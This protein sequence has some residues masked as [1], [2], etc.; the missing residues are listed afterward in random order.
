AGWDKVALQP[1]ESKEVEVAVEPR[2]L[3]TFD[4]TSRTW[5]IGKG[6]YKLMLAQ[7][8]AGTGASSVTVDLPA[9]TLDV[10]GRAR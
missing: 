6:K 1:G 5:R 9:S 4:E 7:D 3:G 10:R 8:A 2:V